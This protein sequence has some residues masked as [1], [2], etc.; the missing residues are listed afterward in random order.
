MAIAATRSRISHPWKVKGRKRHLLVDT[1]ELVLNAKV[2][3]ASV[4]DRDALK[5]KASGFV[6]AG[7]TPDQ[8]LH[9]VAARSSGTWP[10]GSPMPR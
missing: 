8:L 10:R 3:A 2:H 9:T 7:I 1:Q 5:A 6:H 4:F